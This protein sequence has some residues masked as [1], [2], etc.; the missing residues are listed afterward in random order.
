MHPIQGFTKPLLTQGRFQ[1]ESN[2]NILWQIKKPMQTTTRID[3]EGLT[4]SIGATPLFKIGL[5]QQP[6]LRTVQ[7]KLLWALSG[8]WEKLEK[9]FIIHRKGTAQ[10]WQVTLTPRSKTEQKRIFQRLAAKG[11][12]Y[13]EEAEILL[14]SGV[15]DQILFSDVSL[16]PQSTSPP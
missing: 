3:Q 5:D 2:G 12:T 14:P 13:V 15:M 11:G 9:D 6:F 1:V 10:K 16:T 7:Q 8:R 4:Q